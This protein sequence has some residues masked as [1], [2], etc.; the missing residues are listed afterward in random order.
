MASERVERRLAAILAAD[1][2]GYSR[3]MAADEEGTLARLQ[4]HR[5]ELIDPKIT[6]HHGRTVKTTGDGILV[7]FASAVDALRCALEIQQGMANR[8]R[9]EAPGAAIRF[10]VGLTVGDIILQGNDIF[11]DGV[12][13]AARIEGL[14]EPGGI[15][16][17]E[18][19][20][21]QVRGKLDVV[22]EDTGEQPLKNLPHPVRI[23]RVS[24]GSGAAL[25]RPTLA[26][27]DKP[28]IAVLAFQNI[29]GDP[30][31]EYFA[32]GMVDDI[33]TELSRMRWLFVIAR[34][35][36]FTYKGRAVDVKQVGRELGVRYVLEGSI[37]R[38]GDR[39]RITGQLIDAATAAHLWA[40]RFDGSLADVFELQDQVTASVIAAIAPKLEQAEINRAKY[41]PTENLDAYD[42]Y[43]KAMAEFRLW[44]R[45]GNDE[46]LRL[47]GQAY[48]ID[49]SFSS[50]WGMAARCYSQRK[51]CGWL[52]DRSREIAEAERLA[53]RAAALGKDDAVAL[54]SAAIALAYVVGDLDDGAELAERALALNPNLAIAWLYSGWIK[55]WLGEI[56]P[57][58]K[59]LAKA[60]RL[61][62][63]DPQ[64]FNMQ[65]ATAV[66]YFFAGRHAEAAALA[67]KALRQQPN[68]LLAASAL[69]ASS[70]MAGRQTEAQ[71]AIARIHQLD[72]NLRL[73]NLTDLFAIRKPEHFS[74]WKEALRKAG[75]PE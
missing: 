54:T 43:L 39:V 18:D 73:S 49:P 22:F 27:P 26:L 47:F 72:P 41:K 50:A 48:S 24:P 13:I 36:S 3:L 16:V 60:M 38:A 59:D 32:D 10:R 17:S 30:E 6:D 63:H 31:Q 7:E 5:R 55:V 56:D 51:S 8:N 12:N 21:R 20:Y 19:A 46:A 34:N 52:V 1:V 67:E 25:P 74:A 62:P 35:S 15:S 71:R 64:V 68:Y 70:A 29:G 28:S 2:A 23:Y 53:R 42:Y 65:A 61:N 37:R 9:Q 11:G 4:A 69:A 33:I 14:A 45:E 44:T 66:A 58:L 75:L 40:D 57:A